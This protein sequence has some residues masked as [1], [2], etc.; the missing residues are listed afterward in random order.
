MNGLSKGN[1]RG[2][3][4]TSKTAPRND[5]KTEKD[6]LNRQAEAA[7]AAF[8]KTARETGA[9]LISLADPRPLVQKHPV[10]SAGIAAVA[11][12]AVVQL[13]GSEAPEEPGEKPSVPPAPSASSSS[14]T[15][16]SI[17]IAA[18]VEILK[19]ALVP[20]AAE[21]LEEWVRKR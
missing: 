6:F 12:F 21:R 9:R 3:A 11:G 17:V 20:V 7:K 13:K 8:F 2:S 19:K 18:G 15:L 10:S 4:A 16:A 14:P 1:G 5:P